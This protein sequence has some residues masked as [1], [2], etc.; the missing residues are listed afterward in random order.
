MR[1]ELTDSQRL[2]RDLAILI[3]AFPFYACAF[4]GLAVA[5]WWNDRRNT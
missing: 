2:D 4:V 3:I 1:A 5:G